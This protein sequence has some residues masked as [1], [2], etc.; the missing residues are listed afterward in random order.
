MLMRSNK[1]EPWLFMTAT[2]GVVLRMRMAIA[3]PHGWC[4]FLNLCFFP[5]LTLFYEC[6][7]RSTIVEMFQMC[8]Q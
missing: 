4:L 6:N 5:I 8:P 7:F 1:V 2:A 3:T